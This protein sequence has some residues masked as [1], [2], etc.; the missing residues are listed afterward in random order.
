MPS[1]NK[2]NKKNTAVFSGPNFTT[3]RRP[4]PR[5]NSRQLEPGTWWTRPFQ[6]SQNTHSLK[7]QPH[8]S[9]SPSPRARAVT[10]FSESSTINAKNLSSWVVQILLGINKTKLSSMIFGQNICGATPGHW[11]CPIACRRMHPYFT[12]YCC[13]QMCHVSLAGKVRLPIIQHIGCLSF[14]SHTH[15]F[16]KFNPKKPYWRSLAVV[17]STTSPSSLV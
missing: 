4:T 3:Y 15:I 13:L 14:L 11:N 12:T 5:T 10:N 9:P 1:W 17:I 2:K 16:N 6:S 7:S 8:R